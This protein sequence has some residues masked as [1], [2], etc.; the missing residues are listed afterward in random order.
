MC[1]LAMATIPRAISSITGI[2]SRAA[3]RPTAARAAAT[4]KVT[5]PASLLSAGKRPS[6]RFASVT[7]GS[8]A[9]RP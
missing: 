5:E 7:V 6:T 9:P 3:S 4:S 2:P 8:L 1:S